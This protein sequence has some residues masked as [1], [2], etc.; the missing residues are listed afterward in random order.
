MPG[1]L[2][3]GAGRQVFTQRLG[4]PDFSSALKP[5]AG[6][7]GRAVLG[8]AAGWESLSAQAVAELIL[9]SEV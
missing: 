3:W 9:L 4:R 8:D 6:Q 2:S 5:L 7:K 1:F